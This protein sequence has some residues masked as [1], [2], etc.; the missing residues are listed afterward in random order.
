MFQR[1]LAASA[2]LA[3]L[4][5]TVDAALSLPEPPADGSSKSSGNNDNSGGGGGGSADKAT[6]GMLSG[7]LDAAGA[8]L[9]RELEGLS[10]GDLLLIWERW[11]IPAQSSDRKT[12]KK[13]RSLVDVYVV[14]GLYSC[15]F[16]S[17]FYVGVF[18]FLGI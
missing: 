17:F 16:C 8:V 18:A 10:E 4:R 14:G 13:C 15:V 2:R 12:L 3:A 1:Y 6:G 7:Q 5:V 11:P 9:S